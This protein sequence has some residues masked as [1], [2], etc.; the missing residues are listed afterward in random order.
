MKHGKYTKGRKCKRCYREVPKANLKYCSQECY[1]KSREGEQKSQKFKDNLSKIQQKK[2]KG[3]GNN[4]WKGG[5]TDERHRL[6][7]SE[8]YKQWRLNVYKRDNFTC[9]K[10]NTKSDGNKSSILAYTV[11]G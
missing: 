2:Q 8:E 10:C 3:K 11:L 9:R 5:T 6:Q 1:G 4:N 7:N